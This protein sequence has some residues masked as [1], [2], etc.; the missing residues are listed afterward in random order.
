ML[1]FLKHRT[2]CAVAVIRHISGWDVKSIVE[3]YEGYS[4]PKPR[5]CDVK[6]IIEY[7]VSGLQGLLEKAANRGILVPPQQ[8]QEE[9][10]QRITPSPLG[11]EEA[12]QPTFP[13]WRRRPRMTRYLMMSAV[14]LG[15]WITTCV[16]WQPIE[17]Y[18]L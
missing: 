7:K 18:P 10:A 16:F 8:Q 3:E 12:D 6:Y 13:L 9:D 14:A 1:T 15:I 4:A 5:D 11:H 2:G 17:L